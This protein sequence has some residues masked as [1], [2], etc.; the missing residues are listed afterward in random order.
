MRILRAAAIDIGTNSTRLLIAEKNKG[1]INILNR[2]LEITRLGEGVDKSL[3]LNEKAVKRVLR[4]L[5]N[6]R[7][8]L[9]KYNVKN[10]KIVGTSALRDVKNAEVLSERMKEK[11]GMELEI[12]SGEK[13]AELNYKGAAADLENKFL[14][15]DIGGGSTEFIWPKK[16]RK[17]Q[18]SLIFK[19]LDIGC[20]RMTERF[21]K[22]PALILPDREAESI[23]K[24]TSNLLKENEI[25][26]SSD[27]FIRGVGG[28]IT[29]LAAI[30][31]SLEKYDS[32]QI[33]S[34][35]LTTD[36]LFSI[37][38]KLKNVSL[39]KREKITGLQ[40]K[41]ADII[42][43]G[44]IILITV[45]KHLDVNKISVSD[46]DILYGLIFEQLK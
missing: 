3:L 41:R 2:S 29:T 1:G 9:L 10:I 36:D 19:S 5:N 34:I 7:E 39:N 8:K 38:S 31:L 27:F 33:E 15:L 30:K 24:Y 45:L 18:D 26:I 35:R 14:L 4:A 13:E 6:F 12:I 37:Y 32:S 40:P 43:A 28:T 44:V 42:T 11:F 20:V 17:L 21:V 23:A 25:N 46:R 16:D 22:N